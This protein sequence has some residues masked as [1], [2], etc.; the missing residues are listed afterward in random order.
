MTPDTVRF[1]SISEADSQLLNMVIDRAV[2]RAV[3]RTLSGFTEDHCGAHQERTTRIESW[4][5]GRAD[6][7]IAG[8]SERLSALEK[9][10]S[11]WE[12]DRRWT[13]RTV[14]ASV[15]AAC[16]SLSVAVLMLAINL[17]T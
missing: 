2:E 9:S 17:L 3:E 10:I 13:K 1:E 14:I 16:A 4:A 5:F 7:G 12:D 11:E 15:I 6:H 8:A